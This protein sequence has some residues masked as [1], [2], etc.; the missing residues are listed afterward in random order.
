MITEK[1]RQEV[2]ELSTETVGAF[3]K[4]LEQK[5]KLD[6]MVTKAMDEDGVTMAELEGE[7]ET[8]ETL[9]MLQTEIQEISLEL[10]FN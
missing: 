9:K 2:V 7:I 10:G 6:I 8:N 5:R 3:R 4:V 1:F